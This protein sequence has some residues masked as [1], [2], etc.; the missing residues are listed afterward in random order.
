MHSWDCCYVTVLVSKPVER[1]IFRSLPGDDLIDWNSGVSVR[2]YVHKSFSDFDII[3]C[4]GRL[5]PDMSTS[6]TSTQSKVMI[7]VTELLNSRKLRF[8]RSISSA[9]LAWSQNWWMIMIWDLVY[10]LSEPDFWISF[11]VSYHMECQYY[12]TFK[13]PYTPVAWG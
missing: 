13:G 5:R 10:S 8:Y 12:R 11:S 7:K 9:I 1:L 2:T 4:M 3:W 6:M